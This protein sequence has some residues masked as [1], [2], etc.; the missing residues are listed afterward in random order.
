M[1]KNSQKLRDCYKF[2]IKN[3]HITKIADILT[4]R[5]AF[6]IVNIK[7]YIYV[8][9]GQSGLPGCERYNIKSDKW[10]EIPPLPYD[11]VALTAF[12]FKERY[13]IAMGGMNYHL[14]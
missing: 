5:S 14:F 8:I 7:Q 6:G 13:V 1:D 11:L 10:E 3:N 9:S 12:K 2:I 4:G